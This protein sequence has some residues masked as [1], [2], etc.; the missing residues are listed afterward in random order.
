MHIVYIICIVYAHILYIDNM[1]MLLYMHVDIYKLY[2]DVYTY[3]YMHIIYN[4][5]YINA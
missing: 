5:L 3:E 2:M 1:H 4:I